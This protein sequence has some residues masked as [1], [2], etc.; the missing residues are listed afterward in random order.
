MPHGQ[1]GLQ[2][3]RPDEPGVGEI[4]ADEAGADEMQGSK[5]ETMGGADV[6]GL[7]EGECGQSL[8]YIRRRPTG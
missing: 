7:P 5:V 1:Q 6:S 3:V 8:L 2:I 4:R